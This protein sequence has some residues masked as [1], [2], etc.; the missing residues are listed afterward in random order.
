MHE[1]PGVPSILT[2]VRANQQG[3][4]L[5]VVLPLSGGAR[6]L[7]HIL[8]LRAVVREDGNQ[9]NLTLVPTDRNWGFRDH[10]EWV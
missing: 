6:R 3:S 4:Y 9:T 10:E 5:I 1:C 7:A 8:L 2:I